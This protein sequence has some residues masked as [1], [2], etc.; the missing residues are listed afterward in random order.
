MPSF[1]E[2]FRQSNFVRML[3]VR[4]ATKNKPIVVGSTRDMNAWLKA[5]FVGARGN[6]GAVEDSDA[7]A[8]WAEGNVD[9]AMR[10]VNFGTKSDLPR[11][12]H[13]LT[14][15]AAYR[16]VQGEDQTF[17]APDVENA[18]LDLA[19]QRA[20]R[21]LKLIL[22]D[23]P[24]RATAAPTDSKDAL[25][26]AL[27]S[28]NCTD[29]ED[30]SAQ[31]KPPRG[32]WLYAEELE[33]LQPTEP[34]RVCAKLLSAPSNEPQASSTVAIVDVAGVRGRIDKAELSLF[35]RGSSKES[36]GGGS[37]S[38]RTDDAGNR[39]L[40]CYVRAV[41]VCATT[42]QVQLELTTRRQNAL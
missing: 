2:L 34:I 12:F 10:P 4:P 15:V 40:D 16:L 42:G 41:E 30:R 39:W 5:E 1:A 32:S 28:R 14:D 11:R 17:R 3:P 26:R 20:W 23:Q 33:P 21:L 13:G 31:R 38:W 24:L 36:V 18:A 19:R 22:G 29:E 7:D 6:V 35:W 25:L 27:Y 9:D 8:R 37:A